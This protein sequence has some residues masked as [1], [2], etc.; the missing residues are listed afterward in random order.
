MHG[1]REGLVNLS[2]NCREKKCQLSTISDAICESVVVEPWSDNGDQTELQMTTVG[3]K[4][5]IEP[6]P[7]PNQRSLWKLLHGRREDLT[8]ARSDTLSYSWRQK[9]VGS[10]FAMQNQ[11]SSQSLATS[12][13]TST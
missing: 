9:M 6:C 10:R 7:N 1:R 4:S 8:E 3:T 11:F 12:L 5:Q 2:L 13:F